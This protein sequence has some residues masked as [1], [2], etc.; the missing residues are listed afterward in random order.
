M[1]HQEIQRLVEKTWLES[2]HGSNYS[3]VA[4]DD[5]NK[6]SSANAKDDLTRI[7]RCKPSACPRLSCK[8]TKVLWC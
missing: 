2:L 6:L 1:L 8:H 4:E 7:C 5:T 3:G